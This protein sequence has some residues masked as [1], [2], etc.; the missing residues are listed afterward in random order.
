M[1]MLNHLLRGACVIPTMHDAP[2]CGCS[3]PAAPNVHYV[4]QSAIN[5]ARILAAHILPY[6]LKQHNQMKGLHLQEIMM[7]F[8]VQSMERAVAAAAF[9]GGKPTE[10]DLL[11]LVRKV[12]PSGHVQIMIC[13]LCI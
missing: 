9:R 10:K 11:F 6:L 4:C 8:V 1:H 5:Q 7:D 2:H 13:R 3:S 12:R